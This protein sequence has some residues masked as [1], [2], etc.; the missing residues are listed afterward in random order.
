MTFDIEKLKAKPPLRDLTFY[1]AVLSSIILTIVDTKDGLTQSSL[2]ADAGP[3]T[4]WL[5]TH[6]YIRGKAIA[7]TGEVAKSETV[8]RIGG[9]EDTPIESNAPSGADVGDGIEDS[10]GDDETLEDYS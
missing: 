1:V 5:V 3:I 10:L 6:G 4:A 8:A 2:I 7:A 9:F